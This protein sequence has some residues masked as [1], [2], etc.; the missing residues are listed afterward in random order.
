MADDTEEVFDFSS[1]EFTREDLV[2][3]L[4]EMV[5]EYN[6]VSQSFEEVKAKIESCATNNEL[7][8]SRNMQD[9][10]R[11]LETEN[12]NLRSRSEKMLYENQRLAGLIG[13]WTRS[14]YYLQK[15]HGA[16]NPSGDKTGLGYNSDEGSTAKTSS[17]PRL[18]WTKFKTMIFEISSTEQPLEAKSDEVKISAVR[19]VF[20]QSGSSSNANMDFSRWCISAYPAIASDQLLV[21]DLCC[22]DLIVAAVCGNYSSEAAVAL[23]T[24]YH[25][26]FSCC[27]R[28]LLLLCFLTR[29]RGRAEIPHSH[30]PAGLVAL[31]CRVVNYHSSWVGQQ[32]V[33][34]LMHLVFM[35]GVKMSGC[36]PYWG[37]TPRSL[38]DCRVCLL[39]CCSGFP[40]F[41]GGRGYDPA[42]GAPGGG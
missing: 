19:P 15:P 12:E 22:S 21:T 40:G 26:H 34:L 39:V 24:H 4:N 28:A 35:F 33:E 10:L 27:S 30:L 18:E 38:W 25:F 8:S 9:A 2:T 13:S 32:Q 20:S 31:T 7:I 23:H 17:T 5:L 36:S 3:A 41:A 6:K 37:L 11:K 42:G 16:T 14:S 1:P 29:M